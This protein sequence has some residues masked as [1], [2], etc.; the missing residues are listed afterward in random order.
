MIA[1]RQWHPTPVLLPGKSHG[2]RSPVGCSPWGRSESDTTEWLHFHFHLHA[3]EKAMATHS[4]TLAWKIPC[5]EEPG[6]LQSM[7]S[8]RVRHDWAP[9]LSLSFTTDPCRSIAGLRFLLV[10]SWSVFASFTLDL[11][12]T[13]LVWLFAFLHIHPNTEHHSFLLLCF[14][15]F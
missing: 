13:V 1:R 15:V 6:R 14:N 7:G 11:L 8:Q 2:W 12:S 10:T 9:S 4:C 3:L 5:T